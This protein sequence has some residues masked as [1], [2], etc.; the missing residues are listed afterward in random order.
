MKIQNKQDVIKWF[1]RLRNDHP[2]TTAK[3]RRVLRHTK[4]NHAYG[5][6]R[7]MSAEKIEIY[8][9]QIIKDRYTGL[10]D[11]LESEEVI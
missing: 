3:A 7:G 8:T 2:L 10:I 6:V 4:P 1:K 9:D 5:L 11:Y